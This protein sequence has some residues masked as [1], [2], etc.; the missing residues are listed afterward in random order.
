MYSVA[1]C[2]IFNWRWSECSISFFFFFK[3]GTLHEF[4]CHPWAGAVL[5]RSSF[6]ICAAEAS[7]EC[8]ISITALPISLSRG[9]LSFFSSLK[10]L[11]PRKAWLRFFPWRWSGGSD[12]KEPAWNVG[13]LGLIP[14]LGRSPGGRHG[15]PLQYFC[16]ENP[17]GQRSLLGYSR[18][19]CKELGVT[20][21][22]TVYFWLTANIQ[23]VWNSMI[24]NCMILIT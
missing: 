7:T 17:H 13:D 15:N 6:S 18:W 23:D 12:S 16:L 5:Y 20:E 4:A 21:Q 22:S 1:L 19:G 2:L 10:F 9:L 3:Y 24:H 8:S 14:K 11:S